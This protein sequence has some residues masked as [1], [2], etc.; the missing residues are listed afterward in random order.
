[1]SDGNGRDDLK[2]DKQKLAEAIA[3]FINKHGTDE[4]GQLLCRQLISIPHSLGAAGISYEDSIGEVAVRICS[5][6]N[7]VLH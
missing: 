2:K 6:E 7:K 5:N 1:M 3:V 4:A